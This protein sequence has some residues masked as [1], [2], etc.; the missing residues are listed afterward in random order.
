MIFIFVPYYHEPDQY[1][2]D[3][4]KNQTVP[5]KLIKYNRKAHKDLWTHACNFFISELKRYRGLS[6]RD[7]VCIMNSDITFSETLIEEGSRVRKGEILIPEG[8]QVQIDWSKKKFFKGERIDT[9]PGRC[10]FMTAK[11][12]MC[13]GGFYKLLPHYLSD[14]EFGIRMIKKGMKV[15]LI[16][17]SIIHEDHPKDAPLFSLRAVNNPILWTI[18]LLKAGRNKYLPLNILKSWYVKKHMR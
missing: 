1:F 3:C 15:R 16:N 6:D 11:D 9:F 12:L 13:S 10:F 7:V 4:L 18:F 2:M 5:F 14:Y 17:Q 8:N